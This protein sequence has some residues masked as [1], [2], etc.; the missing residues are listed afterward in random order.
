MGYKCDD[1]EH[2][3]AGKNIKCHGRGEILIRGPNVF[4]GYY[5]VSCWWCYECVGASGAGGTG[6][7]GAGSGAGAG[8]GASAATGHGAAAAG[9]SAVLLF[10][11]YHGWKATPRRHHLG[12]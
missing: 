1:T 3:S 12:M 11:C 2:E 8:A 4:P 6:G 10:P 5:K 9:A 7:A